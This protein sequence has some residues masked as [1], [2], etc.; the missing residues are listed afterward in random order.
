MTV[1]EK[2]DWLA[3]TFLVEGFQQYYYMRAIWDE[4]EFEQYLNGIED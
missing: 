1:L 4:Y 3:L 2:R